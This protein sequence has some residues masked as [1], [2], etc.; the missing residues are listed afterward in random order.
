MPGCSV[1]ALVTFVNAANLN[2]LTDT[3]SLASGCTYTFTTAAG[4]FSGP[5]ALPDITTTMTFNGN[6]AILERSGAALPFRLLHVSSAGTLTLNQVTL[7]N[8][9]AGSNSGGAIATEGTGALTITNSTFS[10]NSA[11][12]GGALYSSVPGL[13]RS[14]TAHFLPTRLRTVAVFITPAPGSQVSAL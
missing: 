7:R 9:N 10:A 8:G 11:L 5:T 2:G 12:N 14:K 4:D 6:G 3:I 13:P 1:G